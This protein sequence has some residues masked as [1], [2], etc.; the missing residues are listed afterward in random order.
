MAT[1]DQTDTKTLNIKRTICIGLG[2]TGRDILMQIRR[3]IVDRYGKLSELPVVSFVHIDTDKGASQVAGLKTGDTYHGENM[4]FKPAEFVTA[5]M[6]RQQIDE[7]AQGLKKS[8]EFGQKSPYDHISRWFPP[9][10]LNN[11]Q[12]IEN[13]AGAI[14]PVGR[15]A[16][17]HNRN[18]IQTAIKNADQR[19][20][21][22][23]ARLLSKGIKVDQGLNIIVAGSL[24]GGTGSGTFIDMAY[25]L[26]KMYT[27]EVNVEFISYLVIAPQL[28]GNT[29]VV[30]ANTYA[31]LKEL[32][33]YS[34]EK[35]RFQYD[36]DAQSIF[37]IDKCDSP[38]D[39]CYLIGDRT[40]NGHRIFKK[41][42][43]CHII[44]HRIFAE[45]AEENVISTRVRGIRDNHKLP[46][47]F[48]D[49]HPRNNVQR[50]I[51]FG[52]AKIY[53]PRDLTIA[54]CLNK[55]KL[56]LLTFWLYGEGQSPDSAELLDKFLLNWRTKNEGNNNIFQTK[57]E[58]LTQENDKTFKQTIKIWQNKL[59]G[60]IENTKTTED[61]QRFID[62][63][64]GELKNQFK[65]VQPGETENIRGLWL[66]QLQKNSVK[67]QKQF[68]QDII[69]YLATLLEPSNPNFALDNSRG[70]L[71]ALLTKFNEYVRELEEEKQKTQG[72]IT[73]E[74]IEKKW[75]DSCQRFEDIETEKKGFLGMGKSNKTKIKEFQEEANQ[76]CQNI[77]KLINRN[78]DLI[79]LDETLKI[80][81]HL[82]LL[83]Q[84]LKT[85]ASNFYN[86]L[87]DLESFYQRKGEDLS[88]IDDDE[89]NGEAVFE[90]NDNDQFYQVL[91]PEQ[92]KLNLLVEV[93]NKITETTITSKSI[94][95]FF[96]SERIIAKEELNQTI[97][98]N[99]ET[100]F[101]E[102][103]VDLT[104]SVVNRFMEKYLF[105][106][107]EIRLQ[108]IIEEA[109]VLL[110]LN[111]S[112]AYLINNYDTTDN[113]PLTQNMMGFRQT[114]EKE[115][116]QFKKILTNN[117]GISEGDILST[118]SKNEIIILKEVGGFPLRIINGI[119][120]LK[121]Q[122]EL[123]KSSF[124]LHNDYS[125]NFLDIIPPP[126]EEMKRLQDLFYT[127]LA[128][129]KI[130]RIIP[131]KQHKKIKPADNTYTEIVLRLKD[132]T[133]VRYDNEIIL[134]SIWAE[135]LE[136]IWQNRYLYEYLE[137]VKEDLINK[138]ENQSTLWESYDSEFQ[139]FV[140]K[141]KQ[142]T[143]HDNN[144]NQKELLIGKTAT[145]DTPAREGIL[146]RIYKQF[147]AIVEEI[148]DQYSQESEIYENKEV[149]FVDA[150]IDNP[151]DY[152]DID[153]EEFDQ[154][155]YD[156]WQ[157][158][159]PLE[160]LE[161]K[162]EGIL[163]TEEV[164][165][166]K[167]YVLGL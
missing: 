21:K 12:S 114:D 110:P 132:D 93:T 44:A 124:Y 2:G 72:F 143:E 59:L 123:Q 84:Q 6:N 145:V 11:L 91:L 54:I 112:D 47:T 36:Y 16:F 99:I 154:D 83:V 88:Q 160:L 85:Q 109:D 121:T 166:I 150:E 128:F 152:I 75:Q 120:N 113:C 163:S 45:F 42:N 95:N 125:K 127:C 27:N 130:T 138:I 23:S 56:K 78:F 149:T 31:A 30:K 116:L 161:M 147:M 135:A 129:G 32:D 100:K 136:Q 4:L 8:N 97:T 165:K 20:Q 87:Q 105:S 7:L 33:Y 159:T 46:M 167:K 62:K 134:S 111:L 155:F 133:I 142:L 108:Q 39:F 40:Y 66:T 158:T 25:T 117:I 131:Q 151:Q 53:F 67:L 22:H 51:T 107:T 49:R 9:Q 73:L 35:N 38:F 15:L 70:W 65:K 153:T 48:L 43:L 57:L 58:A 144:F 50:Y 34:S 18:S 17:F 28:Y 119:E 118:Q 139:S 156:K 106:S 101:G 86:L 103:S 55:L 104:A 115:N 96:V 29:A 92:E 41:E 60:E 122:Y 74:N 126:A 10:L 13:G 82:R 164:N 3:L 148:S 140:N 141:V 26:R 37:S 14:R 90:A 1:I 80:V 71:E 69:Q 79:L 94:S 89:I 61:R 102:K 52:L 5:T 146:E 63:M 157:N 68:S 98:L 64:K 81:S 77:T 137:S 162:K 19:T 76:S 24:C